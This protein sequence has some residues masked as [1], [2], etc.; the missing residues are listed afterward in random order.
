MESFAC[1]TTSHVRSSSAVRTDNDD[2]GRRDSWLVRLTAAA[3]VSRLDDDSTASSC[4]RSSHSP[5]P[6]LLPAPAALQA[7]LRHMLP[8]KNSRR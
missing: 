1:A 5:Q 2:D 7:S 4:S 6:T 8:R 3:F